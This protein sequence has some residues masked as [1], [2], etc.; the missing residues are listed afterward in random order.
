MHLKKHLPHRLRKQTPFMSQLRK[1]THKGTYNYVGTRNLRCF[2]I[3]HQT[4][5]TSNWVTL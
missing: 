5:Y 2:T 1:S 4:I 3:S